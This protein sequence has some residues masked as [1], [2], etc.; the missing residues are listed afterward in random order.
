MATNV[1]LFAVCH[2][3][4]ARSVA[5]A[6][7]LSRVDREP[8]LEVRSAGTHVLEGQP[9]SE[10]TMRAMTKVLGEP[11]DLTRQR[12]HQFTS[13]DAEWADVIVTMEWS[14]VRLL[15]GLHPT[16]AGRI[17]TLGYLARTLPADSRELRERLASL[18]LEDLDDDDHDDVVDPAGGD[19]TDYE[20]TM[21]DLVERCSALIAR[22]WPD[23][24]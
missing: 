13:E 3:N 5:A 11:V 20:A 4:V 12:A 24:A 16:A 23:A 7:L 9:V 21:R 2:A 17:A 10:R 18:R 6:Y 1:K 14:Q 19:D 15:R 8:P 22:L